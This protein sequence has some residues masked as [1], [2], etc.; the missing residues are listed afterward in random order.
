MTRATR[1]GYAQARLQARLGALPGDADWQ[2]LESSASLAHFLQS[3]RKGPLQPWLQAIGP[4][5][6]AHEVERVLR[7]RLRDEI[8]AVA[9]WLP[10]EWRAAVEW[11]S[12]LLDLP[13]LEPLFEGAGLPLWLHEEPALAGFASDV[14]QLRVQAVEESEC[15]PLLQHWRNGIGL[16]EAWRLEWRA[17]WPAMPRGQRANLEAVE[18]HFLDHR[19]SLTRP[20]MDGPA[21]RNRLADILLRAFRRHPAQPA[22][23][24]AYLGLVA[25]MLARLRAALV[26]RML[27]A[28]DIGEEPAA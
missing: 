20:E 25:L 27:F 12:R 19:R 10:G 1:F 21:A 23:A 11:S 7:G 13:A 22:T 26:R 9:R 8:A 24:F 18:G 28:G 17:R 14:P 3:A 5:S 16:P 2:R 6:T 15:A 4:H